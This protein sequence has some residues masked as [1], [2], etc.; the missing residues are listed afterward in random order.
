MRLPILI[1]A[2]AILGAHGAAAFAAEAWPARP[3]RVIVPFP[4]GGSNDIV[5][6][7]V[8]AQL[9]DRM[10]KTVVV[11]NRGG[12]GGRIGYE[13]AAGSQPD[14]YTLLVISAAY[15][16]TPALHKLNFDAEKAFVPIA[17]L[18]TG[19]N[20]LA[21]FPGVPAN[22]V[23]ELVAMAKAKPG[24][25][26]YASAGMGTFQHL[27]SELF[28]I[29][30]GIDIVNVPFKGGGPATL[31]VVAG[32][33]QISIGTLIQTLPHVRTGRLRLLGTGG[34]KRVAI[35]PD[36]PTISEAGVPGYEAFNWWGIVA[37]A[38]TPSA[39][40][41]RLHSELTAIV[42]SQEMRK[43]FATE[44]AEAISKSPDEFRKFIG[45]EIAKW[46]KV[47]KT[48]GIKAE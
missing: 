30:A 7:M 39:I 14:G 19:A 33:A 21:V 44:G 9:T 12:A 27:G 2:L 26:H 24:Q 28:R 4:P 15:A 29:M 16:F 8:G 35:V 37:P 40:T 5:A 22:S 47:V 11:D 41:R 34:S 48:A 36:V 38:G 25:M 43:W 45:S 31:A 10:G 3:I 20:S 13:T 17:M 42:A 46:G 6:R 32:Q 1:A 23:K 18:G